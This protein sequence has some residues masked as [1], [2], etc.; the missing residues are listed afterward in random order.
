MA[1]VAS[2]AGLGAYAGFVS[3]CR[4][5]GECNTIHSYALAV[6]VSK[7]EELWSV[8][9]KIV[10]DHGDDAREGMIHDSNSYIKS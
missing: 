5:K 7:A 9:A 6:P 2:L 10:I 4:S 3:Q 8:S 1:V